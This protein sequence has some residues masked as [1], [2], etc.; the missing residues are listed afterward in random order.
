M[1]KHKFCQISLEP[2]GLKNIDSINTR[3]SQLFASLVA[4]RLKQ[5]ACNAGDLGLIPGLGRFPWKRK[6]QPIPVFLPGESHGPRSLVGYSPRGRKESDMTERLHFHF[7][8]YLLHF[9]LVKTMHKLI[10]RDGRAWWAA[11]CGVAQS[12]TRLKRLSSSSSNHYQESYSS[13]DICIHWNQ[14]IFLDTTLNICCHCHPIFLFLIRF[15]TRWEDYLENDDY[16]PVC[17]FFIF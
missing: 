4:Q 1:Y 13:K 10:P 9:N 12:W 8:T 14:F 7:H 3:A 11:V 17:G 6:W 16:V 15:P 5:S 2:N